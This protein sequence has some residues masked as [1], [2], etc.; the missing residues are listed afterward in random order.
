[1]SVTEFEAAA[2]EG[3][4]EK[5]F[6]VFIASLLFADNRQIVLGFQCIRMFSTQVSALD[7]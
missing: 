7:L 6:C 4:K 3:F 5:L 1:M 2:F